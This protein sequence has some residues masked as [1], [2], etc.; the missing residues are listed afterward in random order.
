MI[1]EEMRFDNG[2]RIRIV[3]T[4]SIILQE[5]HGQ[6]VGSPITKWDIIQFIQKEFADDVISVDISFE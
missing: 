2:I 5:I 4:V 3:H 6:S 1:K